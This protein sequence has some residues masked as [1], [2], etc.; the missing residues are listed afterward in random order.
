MDD[1]LKLNICILILTVIFAFLISSLRQVD[2]NNMDA[3]DRLV[4][5]SGDGRTRG[6]FGTIYDS[7]GN[8]DTWATFTDHNS[9]WN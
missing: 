3:Y 4:G 8:V 6:I 2:E 7:E 9:Y 5:I 1:S